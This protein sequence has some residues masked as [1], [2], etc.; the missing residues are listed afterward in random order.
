MT[1]EHSKS[2]APRVSPDQVRTTAEMAR[3]HI[4]SD[5]ELATM[6]QELSRILD[7]A[8][9]L[10]EVDVDGVPPTTHAVPLFC[11]LR[12]DVVGTH[13]DVESTLRNAPATEATFFTVPTII[14]GAGGEG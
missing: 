2:G 8:A 13:L 6:T 4:R 11:P 1:T 7:L 9:D 5:A 12:D 14:S 3:L 10:A